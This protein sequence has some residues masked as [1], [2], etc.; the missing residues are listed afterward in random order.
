MQ[1]AICLLAVV[2]MRKE[3]AHRSEMVSQLLFGEYVMTGEKHADFV[4]V[5]CLYDGYKGWVQAN[6]L[7]GVTAQEV[8]P[9]EAFISTYTASVF[10]DERRRVI[11]SAAPVYCPAG[12]DVPVH[13]GNHQVRYQLP[14]NALWQAGAHPLNEKN[15][16]SAYSVYR[17][18]PYLW[19]G[20]SV[21]GID[22]SGFAQQVFKLF[23]IALLRD[24]YLQA[25]QGTSVPGAENAR[26]G[27]LAFFQNEHGRVTH[28][29]IVLQ[30][31]DI[32]HASGC[33]R[34]DKMDKEGIV[35]I[36]TGSR[37]H[38]LHSVRRFF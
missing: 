11:P 33:V 27:D 22:C 9:A 20:K 25:E 2:P 37:T 7:T 14:E 38:H 1:A 18:A 3:P 21:Y 8:L 19:G 31:G 24:A 26:L 4:W 34:I 36:E 28:V 6:Q 5:Q 12:G 23:G 32:V 16:Q 30:G 35:N 13:F 10:V 17:D 15:L 29:G